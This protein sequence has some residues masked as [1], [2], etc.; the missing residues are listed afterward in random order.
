MHTTTS[1]VL[2]ELEGW[3]EEKSQQVNEILRA[4]QT[5]DLSLTLLIAFA[6][7]CFL[8]MNFFITDRTHL[9]WIAVLNVESIL[10]LEE[11][12]T[13]KFFGHFALVLLLEID[14]GLLS[15][16]D[17]VYAADFSLTGCA[18]IDEE[19]LLGRANREVLD[20][21]TEEHDRLL[22]LEVVQLKLVDS[23]RLL[24]S[25]SHVKISQ[26]NSIDLS[27][28]VTSILDFSFFFVSF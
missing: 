16:S 9:F 23:L 27:V 7:L 5:R 10:T 13:C 17:N 22:V 6:I 2:I 12:V 18:E 28:L 25:F 21:Q 15:V 19:L 3:L 8:V 11:D 1:T 20:E 26:L 4:V 24:F 14:E